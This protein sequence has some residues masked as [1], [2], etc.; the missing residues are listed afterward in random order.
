MFAPFEGVVLQRNLEF[1]SGCFLKQ[2]EPLLTMAESASLEIVLSVEQ[3]DFSGMQE[4]RRACYKAVFPGAA[5][6]SCQIKLAN[7][8]A[9]TVPVHE[10][11]CANY[12]GPLAVKPAPKHRGQDSNANQLELLTPRFNVELLAAAELQERL[13]AG[14]R[15]LVIFPVEQRSLGMH[16]YL[17]AC[18]WIEKKIE[19]AIQSSSN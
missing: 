1:M 13:K 19:T 2:G 5:V 14:Q 4:G 15:G 10:A 11:L 18:R 17:S 16:W 8:S 6:T 9:S 7:P 12:G 3:D